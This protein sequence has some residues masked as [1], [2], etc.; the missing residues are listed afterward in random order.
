MR[1]F[2][3]TMSDG[4]TFMFSSYVGS[5]RNRQPTG[6]GLYKRTERGLEHDREATK[7]ELEMIQSRL[8]SFF[9]ERLQRISDA[10][11]REAKQSTNRP[12]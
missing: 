9:T 3:I 11:N 8:N 7:E 10:S 2:R 4:R 1:D 5:D 12:Q 6:I